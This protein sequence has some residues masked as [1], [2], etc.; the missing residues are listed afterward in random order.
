M[1]N[2]GWGAI[3][4]SD[5]STVCGTNGQS[6]ETAVD[7]SARRENALGRARHEA[8]ALVSWDE[9]PDILLNEGLYTR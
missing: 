1:A 3:A 5:G 6:A 9:K 7:P 4:C 2:A 8:A